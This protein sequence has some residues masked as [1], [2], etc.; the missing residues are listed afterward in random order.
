MKWVYNRAD[1]KSA[2]LIWVGDMGPA[3]NQELVHYFKDRRAWEV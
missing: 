2:K 3:K 1:L